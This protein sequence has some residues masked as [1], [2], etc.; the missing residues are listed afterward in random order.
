[1]R[2]AVHEVVGD[3]VEILEKLLSLLWRES[4]PYFLEDKLVSIGDDTA[5][6]RGME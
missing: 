1:M 5:D 2:Y 6:E 4:F 3:A